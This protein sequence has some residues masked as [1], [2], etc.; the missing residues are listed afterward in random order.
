MNGNADEFKYPPILLPVKPCVYDS[1]AEVTKEV[2]RWAIEFKLFQGE[3]GKLKLKNEVIVKLAC[4]CFP[5][6]NAEKIILVAKYMV[7]LVLM[8]DL[9]SGEKQGPFFDLLIKHDK[10]NENLVDLLNTSIN[11]DKCPIATSFADLW[12]QLKKLTNQQWQ[13]RFAESYIWFLKSHLWEKN[14]LQSGRIPEI[15][16][17]TSGRIYTSGVEPTLC[18]VELAC[19]ISIPE[20]VI[21][22]STFQRLITTVINVVAFE[23]DL[24]SFEKELKANDVHNLVIVMKNAYNI[25]YQEAINRASHHVNDEI[26]KFFH[27]EKLMPSFGNLTDDF[28]KLF[29]EGLRHL[30][31][32]NHDWGEVTGRYNRH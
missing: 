4:R 6:C 10:C 17:Y 21:A 23:N 25:S 2:E 22:N 27:F 24:H 16:E 5:Y 26:Q 18:I 8:D 28:L 20:Y 9:I 29:F 31:R 30:M 13:R 14:N 3:S 7:H 19:N 12:K 32:G 11:Y 15:G 1:V